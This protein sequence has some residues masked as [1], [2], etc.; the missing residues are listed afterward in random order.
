MNKYQK[1]LNYINKSVCTSLACLGI[2]DKQTRESLH[3]IQ[4]LIDQH[5]T[6]IEAWEVVKKRLIRKE[7][8]VFKSSD[9]SVHNYTKLCLEEIKEDEQIEEFEILNKALEGE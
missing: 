2:D 8:G 4:E 5:K 6:K 9:C 1:A 7:Y 3:T